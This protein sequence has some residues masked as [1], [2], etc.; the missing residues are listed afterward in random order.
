MMHRRFT[1]AVV[2]AV[3]LAACGEKPQT[4]QVSAR[5]SDT[6]AYEGAQGAFVSSGWKAGDSNSWEEQ[7]RVR[8]QGQNEYI[9]VK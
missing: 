4:M 2:A 9:R 6:R 1:A 3:A 8:V 7:M 5:K